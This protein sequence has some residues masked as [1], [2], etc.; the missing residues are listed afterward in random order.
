VTN[1]R[2]KGLGLKRFL[3]IGLAI[4]VSFAIVAGVGLVVYWQYLK[5]TPGRGWSKRIRLSKLVDSGAV[6]EDISRAVALRPL[7]PGV[8]P[9]RCRR[10]KC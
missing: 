4:V 9:I 2:K 7:A 5:T 1:D 6:V 3:K 8:S 10:V